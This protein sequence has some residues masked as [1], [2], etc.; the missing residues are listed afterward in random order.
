MNSG[1]CSCSFSSDE[2]SV[3]AP[4][5]VFFTGVKPALA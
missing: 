5:F 1:H 2:A 4:V 3:D